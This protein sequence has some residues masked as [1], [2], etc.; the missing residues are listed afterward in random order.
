MHFPENRKRQVFARY[1]CLLLGFSIFSFIAFKPRCWPC[2]THF[3]DIRLVERPVDY[4]T[5]FLPFHHRVGLES[6]REA[7]HQWS[8]I[9]AIGGTPNSALSSWHARLATSGK[10][11]DPYTYAG[12]Y[13][14]CLMVERIPVLAGSINST[15]SLVWLACMSF[16]VPS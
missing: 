14:S 2:I 5:H 1:P 16:S 8:G 3:H 6:W 15:T 10:G 11:M 4:R 13:Q 7:C 9:E 12:V